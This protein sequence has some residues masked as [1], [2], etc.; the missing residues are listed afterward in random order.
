MKS[1]G[2]KHFPLLLVTFPRVAKLH[3]W[4]LILSPTTS[5]CFPPLLVG[6]GHHLLDALPDGRV[7][8]V[9]GEILFRYPDSGLLSLALTRSPTGILILEKGLKG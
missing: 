8:P 3:S 4:L 2:T 1:V 5:S 9:T 7:S 6:K